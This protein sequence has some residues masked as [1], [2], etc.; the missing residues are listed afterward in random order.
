MNSPLSSETFQSELY[1]YY[2]L[3]MGQIFKPNIRETAS[4]SA[5]QHASC[6]NISF[7]H[8]NAKLPVRI[9][10]ENETRRVI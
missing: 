1:A 8:E 3:F 6:P 10:C 5:N 2:R 7:K 9:I 4:S